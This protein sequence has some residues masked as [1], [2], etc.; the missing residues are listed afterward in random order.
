MN[1]AARW[2]CEPGFSDWLDAACPFPDTLVDRIAL[3]VP[4][5]PAE[6]ALW[7]ERLGGE[8]GDDPL[9]TICEPFALW[10]I[11]GDDALAARIG[12][13]VRGGEGSVVVAPDITPYVLRKVRI[14][15]GLHSAMASIA[16]SK[17]GLTHVRECLEHPELGPFL[18]ALV[19]DE[20]VPAIAPPLDSDDARAY[21]ETTWRRM[22][23]PFLV[24]P[25]AK[26]N[27]GADA[28]WQARLLPTMRSYEER[29]GQPPPRL[30]AC[31]E[32]FFAS[33]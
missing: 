18:R 27:Q 20:I 8:A 19:F 24:H 33:R 6:H 14:L 4:D 17:Y 28:K 2:G 22:S 7:R 15:N 29:F 9:L 31:R 23:N 21:A 10:A 5:D 13:L 11:R 30:T 12:W 26:I 1:L 25:L 32:A 16:P 3:S